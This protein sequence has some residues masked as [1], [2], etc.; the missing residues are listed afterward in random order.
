[1][2]RLARLS[3]LALA[4]ALAAGG[5]AAAQDLNYGAIRP[6]QRHVIHLGVAAEDAVVGSVGYA[7]LVPWLGRRLALTSQFDNVP[8]HGSDWRLR[9]GVASPLAQ[10]GRWMAGGK[11]LGIARNAQNVANRMTNVGLETSAF[12]G[13]YDSSWFVAAEAGL[14]WAA[15]TYIVHTDRY[16][17]VVY[18]GARDGWYSSTGTTMVYGLFGGYSFRNVDVILRA[19]QRRDLRLNTWM[20]PFYAGIAV[21]MRLPWAQ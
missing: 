15:A 1:M 3:A 5:Q 18:E 9:T 8:M 4:V 6:D 21:E 7:Y 10:Y 16:R 17:R 2:T 19:G 12:G 13:F 14:D 20:I 11:A